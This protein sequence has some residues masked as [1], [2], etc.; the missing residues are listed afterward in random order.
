MPSGS[1]AAGTVRTV[2]R[3]TT[4]TASTPA[5][6]AGVELQDSGEETSEGDDIVDGE[7]ALDMVS[8]NI[9]TRHSLSEEFALHKWLPASFQHDIQ[10]HP[11]F[12]VGRIYSAQVASGFF[13]A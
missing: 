7:E 4:T 5:K 12:P 13:P 8:I 9:Y 10:L 3:K 11:T 1:K 6:E 2:S